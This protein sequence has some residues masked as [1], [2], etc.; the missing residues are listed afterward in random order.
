MR[1]IPSAKLA[2]VLGALVA[3]VAL[4]AGPALSPGAAPRANAQDQGTT[5]RVAHTQEI[6]TLNPFTA[7]FL[8]STQVGRLM[9]EYLT[10]NN[11][12]SSSP[13]PGIAE[14]WTTSEDNLTWKFKIREAKW[15][16]GKPITA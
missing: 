4:V 13:E 8:V 14:S 6:D 16:D 12:E 15:S 1:A 11:A 3:M 9:Y 10:V 5:L 7:V 2:G